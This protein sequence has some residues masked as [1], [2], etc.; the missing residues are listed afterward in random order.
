MRRQRRCTRMD[1]TSAIESMTRLV[2]LKVSTQ[3][4]YLARSKVCGVSGRGGVVRVRE[5]GGMVG[6]AR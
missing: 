1:S 3:I 2:R 6:S 4:R 5:A